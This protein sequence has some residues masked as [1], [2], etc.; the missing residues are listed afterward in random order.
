MNTPPHPGDLPTSQSGDGGQAGEPRTRT[1]PSSSTEVTGSF[2]G[3]PTANAVAEAGELPERFGRYMILRKLGRGGMGSVYLAHDTQLDRPVALKV[4]HLSPDPGSLVLERF[5]REA[6]AA[7]LLHHPNICPIYDVGQIDNIPYLTMAFIE[8]QTLAEWAGQHRDCPVQDLATLVGTLALALQEAHGHGLIHRDLKPSNIM[9]NK[10]LEPVIMDFGLARRVN[11]GDERLTHLGVLVG[12]PAYMAPEQLDPEQDTLGPACDIYALGV[13]LYELL[14]GR[15]PFQGPVTSMLAQIV[16]HEPRPPSVYRP[17][18]DPALDAI[19]LKALAKDVSNRFASMAEFAEAL[20]AYLHKQDTLT[21]PPSGR[22]GPPDLDVHLAGE[23]LHFLCTWGWAAGLRKLRIRIQEMPSNRQRAALQAYADWLAGDRNLYVE[24]M[25]R[26]K[27]AKHGAAL[28]GWAL[29]AQAIVALRERNH[30]R[31]HQVLE[32]AEAQC[33]SDDRTLAATIAHTRGAAYFHQGKAD[34]ALPELHEALALFG[35]DHFATGRVLDTLGMVYAGKGNFHIAREFYEQALK[36]KQQFD[37]ESGLALSHG[38]LGRLHLDWGRLDQAEEHFQEDLRLAQKILDSRGEAQMYNHLGQVALARAEREAGSGRRATARRL[39]ADA[40]GW[41]EESIRLCQ[42]FKHQVAEGYARKD[43]ALVYLQE[44]DVSSTE[45]Q[46]QRAQELFKAAHFAEG[47]AQVHRVWG[48]ILRSQEHFEE[49]LRTLRAALAYFEDAGDRAEA[50]RLQWE[51]ARTLRASGAHAALVTRAFLEALERAE[52]CRR[53]PLAAQIEEELR[54]VDREAYFR[55]V[56]CRVRGRAVSDD[57]TSLISGSSEVVT[58]LCFD[59]Q[60]FSDYARGLDPKEV[61]MTL[62]QMMADLAVVLERYRAKVTTY[63]GDGFMALLREAK[64]AERAVNAALDLMA[65]LQEFDRP[66]EILGLHQFQARIGI[67]TGAAFL[68]NVGTYRK[69]DFTVLGPAVTLSSRLLNWAEPGLPCIS[70][71]T[72]ELL[73]DQF[74]YRAGNPRTVEGPGMESC[75]V[76]D[77]VG[78]KK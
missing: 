77:V 58:V 49:A 57:T 52:S 19:C 63:F 25:E 62:N 47:L 26:L 7:A 60:G 30:V 68:G 64:H 41:L 56:Y 38:Q 72:Y 22:H 53:D 43:R 24:G 31:V 55:H 15:V 75:A 20:D 34:L 46:A 44:G 29:A 6:R 14:T 40:A 2:P 28:A 12:T 73:P 33:A 1:D 71:D 21:I 16:A 17:E 42:E 66:R 76:W 78:R 35:K 74:E 27:A 65:A 61:L 18:L 4:P 54:E 5:A 48:M 69:L 3:H 59:L 23:V 11:H 45:Q 39:L 50:A 8:G 51:I 70:Q 9:L 36:H 32:R 13:I 37:D 10:R 67:H